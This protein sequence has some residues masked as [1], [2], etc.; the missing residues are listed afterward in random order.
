MPFDITIQNWL[1]IA[2][3]IVVAA[4]LISVWQHS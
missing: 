4:L 2:D 1:L 3:I